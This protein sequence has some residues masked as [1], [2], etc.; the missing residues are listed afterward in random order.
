MKNLE[1]EI[2]DN[3]AAIRRILSNQNATESRVALFEDFGREKCAAD[4]DRSDP[5]EIEFYSLAFDMTNIK[6]LT[7]ERKRRKG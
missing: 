6:L 7:K 3:T 2:K 4:R 1:S 5:N